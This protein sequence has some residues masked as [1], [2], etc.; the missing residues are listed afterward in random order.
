MECQKRPWSSRK[1]GVGIEH[2]GLQ[3]ARTI[4][5]G[6]EF[7]ERR[8]AVVPLDDGTTLTVT[9]PPAYVQ[10]YLLAVDQPR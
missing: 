9:A 2:L 8:D 7:L 6:D 10:G 5:F 1:L 4:G 3:S